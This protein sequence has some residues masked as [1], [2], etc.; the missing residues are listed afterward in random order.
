MNQQKT[1]R[2][3]FKNT[4]TNKDIF[5]RAYNLRTR[6]ENGGP[7]LSR[8]P[9][10]I[11]VCSQLSANRTRDI[12]PH[13]PSSAR[14][15]NS[16][17][18]LLPPL[19]SH[20]VTS[21]PSS[22]R[23]ETETSIAQST[24]NPIGSGETVEVSPLPEIVDSTSSEEDE[25]S[26]MKEKDLPWTTVNRRCARSL[27]LPS[28]GRVPKGRDMI[29]NRKLTREQAQAVETATTNMT[30]PQKEVL[31]RRQKKIVSARKGSPTPS[32]G[33]GLSKRKGKGIDPQEW[34]NINI[35]RESLD[36]DA[37]AVA[38]E[39]IAQQNELDRTG[40]KNVPKKK[41]RNVQGQS[42]PAES[43]PVAQIAT[44]S[45]LGTALQRVRRSSKYSGSK[46]VFAVRRVF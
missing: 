27:D 39:S 31:C 24:S 44:D 38:L 21:R 12:P 9:M 23:K 41:G 1:I 26:K 14:D 15:T 22:P 30:T 4:P 34:G 13:V 18:T 7:A 37:Q 19:Y 10:T 40:H 2:I 11:I 33:E 36:V 25:P 20:V 5:T 35:S 46:E 29:P 32:Q 8:V 3:Q 17:P 42:L 16:L 28:E 6:T 43:R 45:Y